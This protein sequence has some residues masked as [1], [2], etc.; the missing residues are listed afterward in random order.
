MR[1]L[2]TTSI[3]A[4]QMPFARAE[5]RSL[6]AQGTVER[7]MRLLRNLIWL[8]LILWLI[9]GGLRRWFLPGLASPLLLVRD[10]LVLAIYWIAASSSL[11]PFNGF[12]TWGLVLAVLSMVNAMVVGHGNFLVALYGARCDFL[13]VP[14]IF[15]MA[16]VLRKADLINLGKVALL[17]SVPYTMLMVA[18]FYQPQDAWVNRGLAGSLEGAGFDGALDRFRPP[19]TFS[20]ITGPSLLYPLFT[21]FWFALLLSRKLPSWLMIAAGG[22]ILV[23][24]PISI[25]RTL[26]LNVILVAGVGVGALIAGGRLSIRLAAQVAVAAAALYLLAG[27][28]TAFKDGMLAFNA[29]WEM[30]T[31]DQGGFKAAIVDR[32]LEDLVGNLESVR[33]YGMG[34]GYSTNVGQKSLTSELGFGGSEGEWGRLIFDNGYVLGGLLISYRVALAL[35]VAFASL[36]AWRRGAVIS[37]IFAATCFQMLVHGHWSQ[38]TTLGA[39]IIAAGLALAAA[40][41]FHD[42]STRSLQR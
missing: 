1:P 15:V 33:D 30:A 25:S 36:Q 9:E 12:F 17:I 5:K 21:A 24:I 10:P 2:S 6:A 4:G 11:F 39:T 26:F 38:T 37:L 14:L 18:Q 19:G 8:Y 31:T 13:H 41:N 34:T 29:R 3:I 20:F 35:Y 42:P 23:S 40:G 32:M 7:Q 16:R 27:Y 22:A 28:S